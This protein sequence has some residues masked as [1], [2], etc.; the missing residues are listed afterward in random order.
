MRIP[1][2]QEH[3]LPIDRQ[4]I[5][6]KKTP[7]IIE[8]SWYILLRFLF[9]GKSNELSTSSIST[10]N[11]NGKRYEYPLFGMSI[12]KPDRWYSM[13]N[14]EMKSLLGDFAIPT[15]LENYNNMTQNSTSKIVESLIPMFGFF[16]YELNSLK[17]NKNPNI[18]ALAVKIPV[19]P[20]NPTACEYL[21]ASRAMLQGPIIT[22]EYLD[23]CREITLNGQLFAMQQLT[24]KLR[25]IRPTEQTQYSLV[26]ENGYFLTFTLTYFD[27]DS[28]LQVDAIMDTIKFT[29]G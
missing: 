11:I 1:F 7:I 14:A 16:Q 4:N 23:V 27:H 3:C 21:M 8:F 20:D 6:K 5:L 2:E 28:K 10:R 19:G 17:S 24:L 12:E 15:V 13:S 9:A 29:S 22:T 18:F 26:T 25:N